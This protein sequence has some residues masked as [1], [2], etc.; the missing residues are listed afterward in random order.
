M[1]RELNVNDIILD[2]ITDGVFTVDKD[3]RITSF[4]RAAEKVTQ[5]TRE[6]AIG[7]RCCDVFHASICETACALRE[8]FRSGKP[9]VNRS[10]YVISAEGKKIPQGE[11]SMWGD[12]HAMELALYLRRTIEEGP[13][14]TFFG[15]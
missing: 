8:T 5:V 3:F 9:V 7:Q 4:N 1:V 11:S 13:Y 14:L 12:Y 15:S 6:E 10:V 2:S